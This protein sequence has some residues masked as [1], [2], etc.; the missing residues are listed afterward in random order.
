MM[1]ASGFKVWP[2]EVEMLLY[3]YPGVEEA[4]VIGSPDER[5]GETVK[6]LVV[7][8]ESHRGTTPEEIIAWAR[9]E[10]AAYKCP[11]SVEIVESLLKSA[12]GKV[13]LRGVLG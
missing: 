1:N 2:A 13:L 11:H 8:R 9:G 5:R 4:G 6:A 7:L 10:M 12:R 3:R